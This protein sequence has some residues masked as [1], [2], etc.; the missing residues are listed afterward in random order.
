MVHGVPVALVGTQSSS[1]QHVIDWR[2][3]VAEDASFE[4]EDASDDEE[5]D[6]T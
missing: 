5:E 2:S 3:S 6:A 4:L 1:F